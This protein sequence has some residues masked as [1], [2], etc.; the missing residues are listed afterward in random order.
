M[1]D[2][3]PGITYKFVGHRTVIRQAAVILAG[4]RRTH[5][6]MNLQIEGACQPVKRS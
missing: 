5:V 4:E 3:A 2:H 6:R 1:F